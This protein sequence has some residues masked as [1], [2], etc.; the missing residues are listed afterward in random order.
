MGFRNDF[1]TD[2]FLTK[3]LNTE[4]NVRVR[5]VIGGFPWAR[6]L[7]RYAPFAPSSFGGWPRVDRELPEVGAIRSKRVFGPSGRHVYATTA[8]EAVRTYR[9]TG[10]AESAARTTFEGTTKTL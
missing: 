8:A 4:P 6:G 9:S 7:K 3:K 10:P 5:N 1:N 2:I